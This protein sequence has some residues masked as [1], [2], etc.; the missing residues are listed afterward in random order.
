MFSST[1]GGRY[2]WFLD[3]K[4]S[5]PRAGDR[6]DF[7][8]CG[9]DKIELDDENG[10]VIDPHSDDSPEDSDGDCDGCG[11]DDVNVAG[12]GRTTPSISLSSPSSSSSAHG[13]K[14]LNRA[15]A[16]HL[17]AF[18]NSTHTSM[19]PGRDSAGSNR[20]R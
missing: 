14:F 11:D 1:G 17:D 20:S 8:D 6:T 3:P 2:A 18:L 9:E 15:S 7:V 19:R 10:G 13:K 4:S 5:M 12:G 16:C